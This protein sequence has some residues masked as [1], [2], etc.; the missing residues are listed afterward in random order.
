VRVINIGGFS[1]ELCGGTHCRRTGEIGLFC[2][3]QESSSEAGVRRIEGL[4]R[5]AGIRRIQQDR[6]LLKTSSVLLN[7]RTEELP[8]RIEALMAQVK[9]LKKARAQGAQKDIAGIRKKLLEEAPCSGE[10]KIVT[11]CVNLDADQMGKLADELR[12]GSSPVCGMLA[13]S[14]QDSVVLLGFASKGIKIHI[15]NVV[16]EI[17][18]FLG[19]GGG[20]RP[21]FAKG[22]GKNVEKL[23][24]ALELARNRMMEGLGK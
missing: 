4:T 9:E 22:G 3:T 6:T 12:S 1:R 18:A 16:K 7:S 8:E 21:D 17:S 19:G 13:S 11:T 15:G 5:G 14:S 10:V 23:N 20:G 2:L 24:E